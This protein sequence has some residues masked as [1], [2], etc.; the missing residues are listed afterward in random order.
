MPGDEVTTRILL[1]AERGRDFTAIRDLVTSTSLTAD[2]EWVTTC[3]AAIQAFR[4][5]RPDLCLATH[6]VGQRS[7]LDLLIGVQGASPPPVLLLLPAPDRG[8]DEAAMAAGAADVLVREELTPESLE[9]VLRHALW[10]DRGQ[11]ALRERSLAM[12]AVG[13]R[14]PTAALYV[15]AERRLRYANRRAEAWLGAPLGALA[16]RPLRDALLP[17]LAD[18]ILRLVDKALTG[19][20]AA[21]EMDVP[22]EGAPTRRMRLQAAPDGAGPGL[23]GGVVLTLEDL[24][25]AY[26]VRGDGG[27]ARLRDFAA[28]TADW[29]WETDAELHVTFV[30]ETFE[31]VTGLPQE[32]LAARP[33]WV[34]AGPGDADGEAAQALRAEMEARRPLDA[35]LAPYRDDLGRQRYAALSGKPV[36][37]AEG[38]FA[39][40]RGIGRDATATA[41][42]AERELRVLE[43]LAQ[44]PAAS[45]ARSVFGQ[46][47]LADT[48]PDVF[49][50][51]R[52][53]YGRMLERAAAQSAVRRTGLAGGEV[54]E[55]AQRL[56]YLRASPRDAIAL[57]RAALAARLRQATAEEAEAAMA[58]GRLLLIELLV[59]LGAYFRAGAVV[60]PAQALARARS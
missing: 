40:Y 24:S 49:E 44:A 1:V 21:D 18:R 52:A 50:E 41:D 27:D 8:F 39:G 12:A 2:L 59:H 60:E 16:G 36:L 25:A 11:A 47:S 3:D 6:R 4:R 17:E 7:A 23:A 57:H 54:H 48:L 10:R 26:A 42:L 15:D 58:H 37:D 5:R 55:L 46:G 20:A 14:I 38:R 29:L 9:R 22:R 30:S 56:G 45:F 34:L 35:L 31:A 28:L 13:D 19:S 43:A 53:D 32:A 51:L 33:P